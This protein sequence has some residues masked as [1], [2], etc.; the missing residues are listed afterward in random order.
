MTEPSEEVAPLSSI[1]NIGGPNKNKKNRTILSSDMRSVPG[2]NIPQRQPLALSNYVYSLLCITESLHMASF[3]ARFTQYLTNVTVRQ[4][5]MDIV[6]LY[7]NKSQC[8][9]P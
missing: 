8:L 2:L 3:G 4:W 7:E 6:R 5:T 1:K 9:G